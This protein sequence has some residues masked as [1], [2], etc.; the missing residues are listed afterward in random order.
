MLN[1][2]IKNYRGHMLLQAL[3][4]LPL[5]YIAIFLPLNFS[6]VQHRRSVLD[7]ALDIALQR[8]AVA[9]G[10]TEGIRR[11]TTGFLAEKGFNPGEVLIIPQNYQLRTRGEII[12]IT[13]KVPGNA[14][15]LQGVRVLGGE[16]PQED[17]EIT[18][19]GSIMS[20]L[21]P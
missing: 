16:P 7:N 15:L 4:I 9:G 18:A 6:V 5:L 19:I 14:E 20:E 1:A 3:I 12:Q 13:I 21:L 2:F 11:D 8:A 10:V 17:W